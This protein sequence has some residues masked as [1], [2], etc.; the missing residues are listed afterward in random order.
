MFIEAAARENADFLQSCGVQNPAHVAGVE[1][2][3]AAVDTDRLDGNTRFL[4]SRRQLR[5]LVCRGLRVVGVDEQRHVLRLRAGKAL[6]SML[7][8]VMRL[9]KRMCHGAE[10]G[11]AEFGAREDMG[12][13]I[14]PGDITGTRGE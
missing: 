12:S 14:E 3:I 6:E 7:L 9:D 13:A 8:G 4:Q 10:G 11:N 1:R 5:H 2:E